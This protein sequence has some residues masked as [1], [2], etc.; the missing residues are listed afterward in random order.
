MKALLA[1]TV[2]PAM[3]LLLFGF[4]RA[5]RRYRTDKMRS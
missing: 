1:T 2:V 3:R 4:E 5:V